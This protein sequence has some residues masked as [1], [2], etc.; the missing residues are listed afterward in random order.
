MSGTV[1]KEWRPLVRAAQ[2]AGWRL[3]R[4][5]NNH[6][7][8]MSPDGRTMVTFGGSPSDRRAIAAARALLRRGGLKV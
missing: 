7:R 2:R 4:L 8:L 3:E 1:H 5:R 6:L